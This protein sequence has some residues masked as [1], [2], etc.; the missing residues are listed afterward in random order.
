[1]KLAGDYTF[2][3]PQPEVWKALLDPEVLAASMPGCEKL[4][5]VDGQY[6]GELNI[7]VGPVQGKFTSKI[8]LVDVNEPRAFT[9]KIDG[10]GAPGF[11]KATASVALD[12]AEG[13][14]TKL[15]YEADASVGG[16][17]ATVGQRLIEASAKAIIKQS[18][19]GLHEI[20]K[21]RAAAAAPVT[22]PS[23]EA[24]PQVVARSIPA[25]VPVDQTK[26]AAAVAKEVGKSLAPRIAMYVALAL[27][28][29]L[30]IRFLVGAM[31]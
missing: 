24:R 11:V 4:E 5:L 6:V 16:K 30:A 29:F 1:M 10:R 22:P 7:K 17:V 9:L 27:V 23:E 28:V 3:A 8:D 25:P 14:R 15:T 26:F 21:S 31:K 13:G 12:A 2:Q 19:E 18:L 20:V